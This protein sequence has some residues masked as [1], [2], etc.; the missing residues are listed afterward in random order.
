MQKRILISGATG[1]VGRALVAALDPEIW[2][3]VHLVRHP[4]HDGSKNISWDPDSG[5]IASE[6]LAEGTWDAVV[7]LAGEPIAS[8]RWTPEQ[9]EKIR[10]SRVAGTK[11]LAGHLAE[12][13][14]KPGVLICASA[15]GYY[16]DRGEEVLTEASA[17]GEGFLS[18]VTQAWEAA[19]DPARAAGIRVVHLRLGV[20]LSDQGGA[21]AKMLPVF[22]LGMGGRLGDGSHWMSWVSLTDVTGVLVHMIDSD[23]ASGVYNLTAPEPVTNL[24]FTK[25]LGKAL[26]RPTVLPV[27]RGVIRLALGEMGETLLFHSA[28]VLPQRLLEESGFAF[29]HPALP[30]ALADLAR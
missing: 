12:L 13:P 4:V 16:G 3:V 20:V 17:P 28:K 26:G 11:G 29:R 23:T 25:T 27:P 22:R 2:E 6:K 1:L 14:R 18:D 21:L 7:H 10:D 24:V 15:I 5:L 30:E 19:A 8:K 9:K